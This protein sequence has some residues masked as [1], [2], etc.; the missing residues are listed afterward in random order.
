VSIAS[1]LLVGAGLYSTSNATLSQ[2]KLAEAGQITERFSRAVDQIG[3]PGADKLDVRLGGLYA[4]ERI[5]RDSTGDEPTVTE[6]LSAFVRGHTRTKKPAVDSAP[7][8]DVQAA[9]TIL[10][11]QG[12]RGG[13]TRADLHGAH[14]EKVDLR[15]AHLEHA[16]LYGTHLEGADLRTA[17]LGGAYLYGAHLDGAHVYG[18]HFEGAYLTAVTGMTAARLSL[19][20]SGAVPARP[21]AAVSPSSRPPAPGTPAPRISPP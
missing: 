17:Y 10:G 4:L 2:Q 13:H 5:M 14:L 19:S 3:T 18:A 11:R 9:M 15:G 1:V 21:G 6:V 7:D 16:T 12:P 8:L 20:P